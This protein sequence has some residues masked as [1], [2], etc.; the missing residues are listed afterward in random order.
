MDPGDSSVGFRFLWPGYGN[1][2]SGWLGSLVR[3]RT[4]LFLRFS[5]NGQIKKNR[6]GNELTGEDE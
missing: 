3:G 2:R 4:A 5:A 6:L 1:C